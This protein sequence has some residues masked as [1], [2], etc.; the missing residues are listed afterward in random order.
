A[1][2]KNILQKWLGI[3]NACE[4][5]FAAFVR[6][7]SCDPIALGV[8]SWDAGDVWDCMLG[9]IYPGSEERLRLY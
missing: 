2:H 7:C 6:S 4:R 3:W 9:A 1:L 5:G 8:R